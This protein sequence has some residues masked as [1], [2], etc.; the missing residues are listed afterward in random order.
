M[1]AY[2][3]VLLVRHGESEANAAGRFACRTWDPPLTASGSLEAERLA[4][5][6]L[7]APVRYIVTSPLLRARQ[8]IAPLARILHIDPVVLEDLAEVD[9]GQWDGHRLKD[10][11]NANSPAFQAWRQDPESNPPPGGESIMTVGQRV[12]T[13]LSQFLQTCEPST[14]TVAAT[15]ADCIK[16]ALLVILDAHGPAARHIWVPNTGQLLLRWFDN[17][18]WVLIFSPL[19]NAREEGCDLD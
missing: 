17:G 18:R 10:L 16:G 11:E 15:H 6:L 19:C 12:L 14:L 1:P 5:Q 9:L 4:R 13:A 3:D 8:T 7:N 2:A